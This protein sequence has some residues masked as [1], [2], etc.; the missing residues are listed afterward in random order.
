M[1]KIKVSF[2]S[3]TNEEKEKCTFCTN[4][5]LS[6]ATCENRSKNAAI[7]CCDSAECRNK[8][9]ELARESCE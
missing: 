8:A 5:A 1:G 7:A 3:H 6:K 2:I 4:T 9:R